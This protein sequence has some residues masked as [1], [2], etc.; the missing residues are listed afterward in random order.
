MGQYYK[1]VN[2]DTKKYLDAHDYNN[3]LKLMVHS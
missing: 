1:P 2:L 3:G